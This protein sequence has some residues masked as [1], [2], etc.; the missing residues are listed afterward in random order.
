MQEFES[1]IPA[2]VVEEAASFEAPEVLEVEAQIEEVPE[3]QEVEAQVEEVPE[4]DAQFDEV[5]PETVELSGPPE[6]P[7]I[8]ES[9]ISAEATPEGEPVYYPHPTDEGIVIGPERTGLYTG[10]DTTPE[11]PAGHGSNP[12]WDEPPSGANSN[13]PLDPDDGSDDSSQDNIQT[14][15]AA[16]LSPEEVA[17]KQRE[18]PI[19][20]MEPIGPDDKEAER[21]NREADEIEKWARDVPGGPE[22]HREQLRKE[23]GWQESDSETPDA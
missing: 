14:Q 6:I 16:Y 22:Y 23:M 9:E 15:D 17:R 5:P 7:E 1:E 8:E 19:P 3:V 2:E 13:P 4:L 10:R 20:R 12:S 18:D 11:K 21:W